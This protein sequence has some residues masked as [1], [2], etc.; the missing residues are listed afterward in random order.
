[1]SEPTAKSKVPSNCRAHEVDRAVVRRWRLVGTIIALAA[2]WV[3]FFNTRLAF[4]V[5]R[6]EFLRNEVLLLDTHVGRWFGTPPSFAFADRLPVLAIAIA[7][8]AWCLAAGD[9]VLRLLSLTYFGKAGRVAMAL[10]VGASLVSL[11]TLLAGLAGVLHRGLFVSLAV[12]TMVGWLAMRIRR[13]SIAAP[14]RSDA[15]DLDDDRRACRWLWAGLPFATAI[16]LSSCLPP[17]EFDVLEYHLQAPKEF[18]LAGRIGFLPHN[19]YAN[20]TLGTEMHSLLAMVIA[21]DWWIGGLAGKVVSGS[22]AIATALALFDAGRRY[23]CTIAGVGAALIYISIPWVAHVSTLGL[24]DGAAAYYLIAACIAFWD[25]KSAGVGA[26]GGLARL[27]LAGFLSGS[28]VATKYPAVLF[29]SLPLA[30][31]VI[32][33]LWLKYRRGQGGHPAR[34]G[35]TS[36]GVYVAAAAIACG[37]WLA[38]NEVLAGNPTYPLLYRVFGGHTRTPEKDEQ[39]VKAHAPHGFGWDD[40]AASAKNVLWRSPWLSPIVIP[41][42]GL[43]LVNRKH[44]R[45]VLVCWAY[46]LIAL[47]GWWLFT[48][49]IDRFW[50]PLLPALSLLGGVA[51]AARA[52]QSWRWLV[53]GTIALGMAASFLFVTGGPGGDPGYFVPLARLA[54][55]PLRVNPWHLALNRIVPDGG[56]LLSVGNAA[57]YTLRVP[58]VYSTVFDDNVFEQLVRGRTPDEIRRSLAEL[59]ITHVYVDW[60]FVKLYR[61]PGNYGYSDFVTPRVFDKLV[62]SGVLLPPLPRLKGHDAEVYPVKS[63]TTPTL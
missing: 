37:P 3:L 28:A 6:Y 2:Y 38:K 47:A 43:S 5:T 63:D 10:A 60:F 27:A 53:G 35:V 14:L 49:R 59:G 58:V 24:V 34:L 40:L 11:T 22:F 48:H 17:L 50:I 31:S 44:R 26:P 29:V 61:E 25:W 62:A 36:F 39:W 33:T 20:M 19:V 54:Q 32:A 21:G 56:R 15:H 1:M 12:A 16:V 55:D 52:E 42:A 30:A 13:P 18:Y 45:G 51:I 23:V 4:D 9:L 41:L 7:I 46:V 8:L 57:V